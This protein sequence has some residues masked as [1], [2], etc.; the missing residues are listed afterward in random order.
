MDRMLMIS[1]RPEAKIYVGSDL[2]DCASLFIE[3]IQVRGGFPPWP[4]SPDILYNSESRTWVGVTY[5]VPKEYQLDIRSRS[6]PLDRLVVRY[7][8]FVEER[9]IQS[10]G[11]GHGDIHSLEILWASR[12]ADAFALAQLPNDIW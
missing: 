9:N 2:T 3:G 1:L 5:A 8:D 4:A 7:D 10:Y 6:E 12:K 11:S